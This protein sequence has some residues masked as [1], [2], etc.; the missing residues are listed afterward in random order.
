[1]GHGHGHSLRRVAFQVWG[2]PITHYQ[3]KSWTAWHQHWH[4]VED[5]IWSQSE[6]Y[7]DR[8]AMRAD[9]H[10]TTASRFVPLLYCLTSSLS[11]IHGYCFLLVRKAS[12]AHS[13]NRATGPRPPTSDLKPQTSNLRPPQTIHSPPP[14][15]GLFLPWLFFHHPSSS[16]I[17]KPSFDH[18]HHQAMPQI[19]PTWAEL[20]GASV[21]SP[22][23]VP[24]TFPTFNGFRVP[25]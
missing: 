7:I 13:R 9:D 17:P 15:P 8:L 10:T 18:R 25:T 22:G 1:M 6:A 24:R 20:G 4:C 21:L 14:R 3:I 16:C 12:H 11:T 5:A 23:L 19:Q 2:R